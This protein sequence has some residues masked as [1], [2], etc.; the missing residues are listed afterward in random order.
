MGYME[1]NMMCERKPYPGASYWC[2][3]DK[4]EHERQEPASDIRPSPS[5]AQQLRGSDQGAQTPQNGKNSIQRLELREPDSMNYDQHQSGAEDNSGGKDQSLLVSVEKD[6]TGKQSDGQQKTCPRQHGKNDR[7]L[8]DLGNGKKLGR[9][10]SNPAG[11]PRHQ[12]FLPEAAVQK[13]RAREQNKQRRAFRQ[14]GRLQGKIHVHQCFEVGEFLYI[15]TR[16]ELRYFVHLVIVFP[17]S[18]R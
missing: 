11:N 4:A 18:L 15:I 14:E 10:I 9:T 2:Y 17:G 13:Y 8:L 12:I 6:S 5:Q 1:E 16:P 7:I 3:L